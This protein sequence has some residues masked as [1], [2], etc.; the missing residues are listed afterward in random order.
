MIRKRMV[1]AAVMV[2]VCVHLET[3]SLAQISATVEHPSAARG[4]VIAIALHQQSESEPWPT[5]LAVQRGDGGPAFEGV[6][7]WIGAE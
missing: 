4:G 3:K 6:I 7:A 1:R 2:I 5:H